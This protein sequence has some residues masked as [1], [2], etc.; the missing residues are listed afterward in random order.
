M[1][2]ETHRAMWAGIAKE[3]GWYAEPFHIQV[4][5][6]EAGN[7]TDSVASRGLAHDVII[8]QKG[9]ATDLACAICDGEEVIHTRDG[10]EHVLTCSDCAT[11][12][13]Y[14]VGSE[15]PECGAVE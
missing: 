5:Q 2:I 11:A 1:S 10:G 9:T 15:C 12:A 14:D 4:W 13:R 8:Q 6:D 3:N 7:I